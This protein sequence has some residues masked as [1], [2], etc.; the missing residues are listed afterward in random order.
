MFKSLNET[1]KKATHRTTVKQTGLN[2]PYIFEP[3]ESYRLIW[4]FTILSSW[5]SANFI[6]IVS[7]SNILTSAQ[8]KP[9]VLVSVFYQMVLPQTNII[10]TALFSYSYPEETSR[11]KE[12]LSDVI[13]PAQM[14]L[15]CVINHRKI[16]CSSEPPRSLISFVPID[17]TAISETGGGVGSSVGSIQ[18]IDQKLND[19][20]YTVTVETDREMQKKLHHSEV[21]AGLTWQRWAQLISVHIHTPRHPTP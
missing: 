3:C 15:Q 13:C 14:R 5:Y 6:I 20:V 16:I 19:L 10:P 17:L 7:K 21:L 18:A 1:L 8:T 2:S 12:I 11:G 9:F 4:Q